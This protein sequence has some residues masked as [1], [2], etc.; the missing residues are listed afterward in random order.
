MRPSLI[1][2]TLR[3][4]LVIEILDGSEVYRMGL[5][6]RWQ[7]GSSTSQSDS[8]TF[9]SKTAARLVARAFPGAS[10]FRLIR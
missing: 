10:L 3:T 4:V 2:E 1:R 7:F 6:I 9:G 5:A 8:S